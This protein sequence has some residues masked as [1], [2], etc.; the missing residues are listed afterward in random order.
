MNLIFSFNEH[1]ETQCG[2]NGI[3]KF[4]KKPLRIVNSKKLN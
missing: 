1:K 3:L 2:Q 4:K